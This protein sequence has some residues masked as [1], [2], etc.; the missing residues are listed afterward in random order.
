MKQ[1]Y[2]VSNYSSSDE[3]D[4]ELIAYSSSILELIENL[5]EDAIQHREFLSLKIK[6]GAKFN[7]PRLS[8]AESDFLL[9]PT[10]RRVN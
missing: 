5:L 6:N 1:A 2:H 9:Q 4:Q 8:D 10:T 7:F 3:D